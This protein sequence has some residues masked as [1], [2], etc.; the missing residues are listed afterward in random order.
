[1]GGT[2]AP[3]ESFEDQIALDTPAELFQKVLIILKALN[4]NV[5]LPPDSENDNVELKGLI[6]GNADFIN[7]M[8]ELLNATDE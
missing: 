6:A 3:T 7:E 1:M 8:L 4:W 5:M 2:N